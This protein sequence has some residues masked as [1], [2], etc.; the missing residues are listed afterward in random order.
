MSY[1]DD[2]FNSLLS[3]S[4]S[5]VSI[6][7][8]GLIGFVQAGAGAVA[9]SVQS[10]LQDSVSV[11]DFGAVGDGVTDDTIAIQAAIDYLSTNS[12]GLLY[13]PF[14]TYVISSV[15]LKAGVLLY[16]V[17]IT[18]TPWTTIGARF[19]SNGASGVM[20]D[21]PA[22]LTDACGVIG[23]GFHGGGAAVALIGV[24]FRNVSNGVLEANTFNNFADQAIQ[25]VSPSIVCKVIRNF[26]QNCLL[27][28]T[29]TAVEGCMDIGGTDH[30]VQGNEFTPSLSAISSASLFCA[31][32]VYRCTTS[33]MQGNIGELADVG[34]YISGG[35]NRLL[36]DRADL[37]VGH[38][39][40]NVGA[41]NQFIGCLGYSN[42]QDTT[43][44]YD[45]FIASSV[46]AR[47]V[48][49]G[50][51]AGTATVKLPRYGFN[52][53][54]TSA[55]NKNQYSS[56]L[57]DAAATAQYLTQTNN[58]SS[59]SF[60]AGGTKVLT[61]NSTTPDVT[62]YE[63]FITQNTNPT[64]YTDFLN[65]VQGQM[66]VIMCLDA[67]SVIQHNGATI[68][69]PTGA[70]ITMLSGTIYVAVKQSTVWRIGT[71]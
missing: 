60:P 20:V 8:S 67:N 41:I 69:T 63:R 64:T 66:M 1:L 58:G 40:S 26:G 13:F 4:T 6:S 55:A 51:Y 9:R 50:C 61:A 62:G 21:T 25:I 33:T 43:N 2:N 47:N 42:S 57:S 52:D 22:G 38:G 27:N 48:Y 11:K 71:L 29:R 18:H 30:T 54:V 35:L 70:N 44:T 45:N 15:T 16:G 53:Q 3:S 46:T 24:R 7:G 23:M 10:R 68:I 34:I 65:G 19:L 59:F 5:T 37:N 36:G 49:V 14:G 31:A 56:C 12:G 32:I 17:P 28:R 39:V